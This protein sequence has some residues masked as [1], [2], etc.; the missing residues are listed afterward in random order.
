MPI[1]EFRCKNCGHKF[2]ELVFSSLSEKND[3]VCPRCGKKNAEKLLSAFSSGT[4]SSTGSSAS[5]SCG[6]SR[7]T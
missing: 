3:V 4:A 2:E 6:S 7:F 5:S 1:Y